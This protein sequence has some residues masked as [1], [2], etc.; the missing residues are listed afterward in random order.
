MGSFVNSFEN[1]LLLDR[2]KIRN[3]KNKIKQLEFKNQ[4]TEKLIKKLNELTEQAKRRFNILNNS[5]LA[6]SYPKELPISSSI[7][8]IKETVEKHQVIVICGS[9]GSG[10]TTQ[11]PKILYDL[12]FGQLGKIACTQPR[13][14]AATAMARRLAFETHSQ[15]GREV[16]CKVRFSDDTT[17]ETIVEFMTDGVLLAESIFDRNLLKYDAIM[18]DEAHERSLNIDFL[19]GYIKSILSKRSEM[20]VIISS[21]TL[22]ADSFSSF[23]NNAP[24]LVIDGRTFPIEDIYM[25]KLDDDEDLSQHIFRSVNWVDELDNSGNILVFLPG[26]REIKDVYDM[27]SGKVWFKSEILQLFGR[28]SIGDQQ[29]IF[30]ETGKRKIILATNVAETSITIPGIKY[31]IDS[32]LAKV[33]RYDPRLRI[34]S[35]QTEF[36]SK[37]S[38]KQ[39]RGRCGRVSDG[40]CVHLYDEEVFETFNDFTEP[41]ILRTSLAGVILHMES[42][43]LP[44]LEN[45]PLIDPPKLSLIREGYK[46]L[47]D[48]GAIEKNKQITDV[49]KIIAELPLDPQLGKLVASGIKEKIANEMIVIAAFLS[50]QDPRERPIEKQMAADRAHRQWFDTRSDFASILKLWVFINRTDKEELTNTKLR[51]LCKDNFLNYMRI[52]EWINLFM[53]IKE[54]L[55]NV[56]KPFGKV[57]DLNPANLDFVHTAIISAFPSNVG[58]KSANGVYNG[59]ESKKIFIF[60]GSNVFKAAPTWIVA[61]ALMETSKLFARTIAEIQPQWIEAASPHLCKYSYKNIEWSQKLGY[62]TAIEVS[63]F[64]G[65]PINEGKRV[66]YGRI[67]SEE[68][69]KIFIRD[70]VAK[71]ALNTWHE[72]L[73]K[74]IKMLDD[75]NVIEAK[76]RRPDSLLNHDAVYLHF[77]KII[78][79]EVNT[80]ASLI[81]WI[82][83]VKSDIS[84]SIND[85]IYRLPSDINMANYPDALKVGTN[86]YNLSYKFNPGEKDDGISFIADNEN[87]AYLPDYIFDWLV[88]GWLPEKVAIIFKSLRKE[89]RIALSP[90]QDTVDDFMQNVS[91]GKISK[92]QYLLSAIIKYINDFRELEADIDDFVL[93]RMPEHLTMKL[94]IV[95][96]KGENSSVKTVNEINRD[97]IKLAST[98]EKIN[99]L[100]LSGQIQ[101]PSNI[102]LLNEILFDPKSNLKGYRALCDEGESVGVK[103]YMT[104]EEAA[105]SHKYGM[106]RLFKISHNEQINFLKKKLPLKNSTLLSLS[107]IYRD[108]SFYDEFISNAIYLSL[109]DNEMN[110]IDDGSNFLK[111][112]DNALA[113]LYKK[114][115]WMGQVIDEILS[116]KSKVERL[117]LMNNEI[118]KISRDDIILQLKYLFRN[119]FMDCTYTWLRYS[120]YL[121]S[122]NI[123]IERLLNIPTKD[124]SK[125]EM[126][127]PFSEQVNNFLNN[128]Y[129]LLNRAF[130]FKKYFMLVEEYRISVFAPEIKTF[131][132]VSPAILD[133]A[134]TDCLNDRLKFGKI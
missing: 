128:D 54:Y 50:I 129:S 66:H 28:L 23:F 125:M 76:I 27:L 62:V 33:N 52:R 87:Q 102:T 24:I 14:L 101:W 114:S 1:L 3:L 113:V 107:N 60:P 41:E 88:A 48:I 36:I 19:L 77:E 5:K 35:L 56:D 106:I 110:E 63:T 43:R 39:R 123:R 69:R 83:K 117:L 68:A 82:D 65:L 120:K 121:K 4:N 96:D 95:D 103:C 104:R 105:E 29:R 30:Q 20:K 71:G 6:I 46:T 108:N 8:K 89:F 91:K 79:K 93:D 84:M 97:D 131:E 40:I 111:S 124:I 81:R 61:A 38:V 55:Q 57:I 130:L 42:L 17:D 11:L 112:S 119:S 10:K 80:T 37:A 51:K 116:A 22:D 67:N 99:K 59:T 100:S 45:F 94:M 86:I 70:G 115:E 21:A 53:D 25:P 122:I 134:W 109:T 13:R 26:E 64:K 92:E 78:P 16:G 132:K 73:K 75:I 98:S 85:A 2:F 12:G 58:L 118:P 15:Y 49:G 74:H 44:P 127:R 9:T 7:D 126:L 34:Q 47:Y 32:G 18:I 31:V 133:S 90:I 72:W